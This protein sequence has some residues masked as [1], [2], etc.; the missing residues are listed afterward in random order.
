MK[1]IASLFVLFFT[2]II[3]LGQTQYTLEQINNIWNTRSVPLAP[4]NNNTW[5]SIVNMPG[6]VKSYTMSAGSI[7]YA[8]SNYTLV[9]SQIYTNGVNS[10]TITGNISITGV[11]TVATLSVTGNA[12]IN[13]KLTVVGS[14]DPTD[15]LLSG[16]DK[17]FGATDAGAVYLAPFTDAAGA[18]EI[19][20]ADN[21]TA[22]VS[23]NTSTPATN[24][25]GSLTVT[26][27]A[28]VNGVIRGGTGDFSGR[29]SMQTLTV[30]GN[31]VINGS[32]TA[33]VY[34]G[35]FSGTVTGASPFRGAL[36]GGYFPYATSQY[37]LTS[38]II[39]QQSSKIGINTTGTSGLLNITGT[40]ATS[41][42][43]SLYMENSS[44][45]RLFEV[46]DDGRL[47]VGLNG[48]SSTQGLYIHTARVLHQTLTSGQVEP[49]NIFCGSD[50][51]NSVIVGTQNLVGVGNEAL[52]NCSTGNENVGVGRKALFNVTTGGQNIG[53]GSNSG[54]NITTTGQ[55]I[56]IGYGAGHDVAGSW[57][58]T[59]SFYG[60]NTASNQV[61]FGGQ[62]L[63]YFDWYFG[64]GTAAT[65]GGTLKFQ[66]APRTG[67]NSAGWNWE[68]RGGVS[69][70]SVSGGDLIFKTS[71][72]GSSGSSVN[73]QTEV[74]RIKGTTDQN[75]DITT[76][77]GAL[78]LP[79]LTSTQRDALTATEGM[80]I[81]NTTLS[82]MQIYT[83]S[84]E[85]VT[86]L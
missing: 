29:V 11:E 56:S 73:T 61:A 64:E 60:T 38:S 36:T 12:K 4:Y 63:Q 26:G 83:T 76:T 70:G 52:K 57:Q 41:A 40:G 72:P 5:Y 15:V 13:G 19:R 78:I 55:N 14:I 65:S 30:T 66:P 25:T 75:V 2:C 54:T 49:S 33:S 47:Y 37:T 45:N 68:I 27:N 86:S 31:A 10:M 44:A 46:T 58:Q 77:N 67:T 43:S 17:R 9:S 39:S 51:G 7:P 48:L 21:T 85:T 69:T 35:T 42:T 50:A 16:A 81:Y 34:Y 28:V 59:L 18:I 62:G 24:I 3:C 82:K 6:S 32:L 1:R 53:I 20:K 74:L 84:W 79:R 22:V 8:M 80:L 71:A 23:I